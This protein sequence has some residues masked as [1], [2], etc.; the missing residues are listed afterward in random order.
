MQSI[1]SK[2]NSAFSPLVKVAFNTTVVV[3]KKKIL[4]YVIS[5]LPRLC[6]NSFSRLRR[7]SILLAAPERKRT[8]TTD[9]LSSET[10]AKKLR[11]EAP[12]STSA[13]IFKKP[14]PVAS[15]PKKTALE[16][17]REVRISS[18]ISSVNHTL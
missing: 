4:P 13:S 15:K 12:D 1:E 14:L 6:S 2:K 9:E 10:E 5:I 16:E 11:T 8:L 18:K 3:D 7:P 17:V